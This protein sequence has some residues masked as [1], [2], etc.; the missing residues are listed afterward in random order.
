LNVKCVLMCYTNLSET[1]H[2]LMRNELDVI[3]NVYFCVQVNY[4]FLLL[5]FNENVIF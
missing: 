2:I 5:D 3:K 4:P 1:F